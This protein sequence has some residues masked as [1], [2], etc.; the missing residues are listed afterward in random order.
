MAS[1]AETKLRK[2][3]ISALADFTRFGTL[4]SF[5]NVEALDATVVYISGYPALTWR[6][7]GGTPGEAKATF[8]QRTEAL[9]AIGGQIPV[10]RLVLKA[11][12]T[13]QDL[14]QSQIDAHVE[15][16][17]YEF[18]DMFINGDPLADES[19]P[20]GLRYRMTNEER[21]TSQTI[22][23]GAAYDVDA[24]DAH[25]LPHDLLNSTFQR[26]GANTLFITLLESRHRLK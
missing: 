18:N 10:D 15:A 17:A 2:G 16:M 5:Q 3:V 14:R 7:V 22:S 6:N 13:V 1:L 8:A 24:D 26:Q 20:A 21:F 9:K 4:M 12:N 11:K 25:L 19:I 23:A